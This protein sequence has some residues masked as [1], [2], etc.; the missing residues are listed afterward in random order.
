MKNKLNKDQARRDEILEPYSRDNRY[1]GIGYIGGIRSF[2]NLPLEVLE[3]LIKEGFV[4]VNDCQNKAPSIRKF[5]A[6]MRKYPGKFVVSGYAVASDRP[7]YRVSVD[8]ISSTEAIVE[9]DIINDF[10][11]TF[12]NADEYNDQKGYLMAWYD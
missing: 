10:E 4:D 1:F 6:F 2:S 5:V 8:T 3:Q 9:E 11:K 7:D 12:K